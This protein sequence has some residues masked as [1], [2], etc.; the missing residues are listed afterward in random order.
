MHL[1][2]PL[3]QLEVAASVHCSLLLCNSPVVLVAVVCVFMVG[4][5]ISG[6]SMPLSLAV[7]K[8]ML[9]YLP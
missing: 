4:I 6:I 9:F 3:F 8:S 2:P 5:L 1:N 7:A